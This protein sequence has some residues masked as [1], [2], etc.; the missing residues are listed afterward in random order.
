MRKNLSI[1]LTLLAT[2]LCTISVSAQQAYGLRLLN[3][4]DNPDGTIERGFAG[5]SIFWIPGKQANIE[6]IKEYGRINQEIGINGTVLNNVNAKPLMLSTAKLKETKRIADALRPYG[7]KVYLSVNFASPKVLGGL[8]TADP[9]DKKVQQWW[10]KKAKEI[11]SLIPDFGGFLVKA[12]SEGEPGPMDY[13]RN[14]ADGAN[15]LAD[16]LT[17]GWRNAGLEG[18]TAQPIV[19]WRAFVYS[20][21]AGD[22]A[23]QAYDEFMPFDGLFRDNVII[24]VKLGPVDFQPR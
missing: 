2:F 23:S 18:K 1:I 10:A 7:I 13:G 11:Y 17:K 20:P 15:M 9:L 4:W 5:H 19:M 24:Q 14:H 3:H 12:N 8:K 16:A 6:K 21:K 22:R